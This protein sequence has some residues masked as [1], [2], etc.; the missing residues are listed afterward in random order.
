MLISA[1]RLITDNRN[2]EIGG[3]VLS[4]ETDSTASI[5]DNQRHTLSS[6]IARRLILRTYARR[7]LTDGFFSC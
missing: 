7:I 3:Q 2:V 5:V 6:V 1:W 4:E